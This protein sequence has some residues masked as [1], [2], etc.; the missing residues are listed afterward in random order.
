MSHQFWRPLNMRL[1]SKPT[2][3]LTLSV[4]LLSPASVMPALADSEPQLNFKIYNPDNSMLGPI[5]EGEAEAETESSSSSDIGL[6]AEEPTLDEAKEEAP[7]TAESDPAET[8]AG[9][10]T[11]SIDDTKDSADG[12]QSAKLLKGYV[13]V[14]PTGTKIPIIMDTAVDSDTSQ[15][16]DEF[17][18]RT[19]E[20][21]S[22]DGATV[23][24]AGSIIKGRIA[25][26]NSPRHMN[27]SGSVAM[28]FDT[29]T[30]PDNRQIPIVANLVARGGVV[31]A[32]RG[33]KDIAIDTGAVALPTLV[34]L[35]VGALAGGGSNNTDGSSSGMGRAGGAMIG[36]GVGL[37]V[38]I[39]ILLSKK[40]KKVD[41]R[42]GDEFKIQLAE[43]LRMPMM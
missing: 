17:S 41:L 8:E 18:A 5:D 24:P 31:H 28:K 36:A 39:A 2:L 16:A 19:A 20:D 14:V 7:E 9:D 13:R 34:G 40:G 33:M 25:Q 35:G 4:L 38:G 15:E 23:I 12:K 42:P 6:K 30:T 26:L 29:I 43:E 3:A 10:E 1:F 27:R 21:L 22:I 32:K 37:A 11:A